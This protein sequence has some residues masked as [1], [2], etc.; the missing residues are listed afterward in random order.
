M[1]QSV[2]FKQRRLHSFKLWTSEAKSTK[3]SLSVTPSY[4]ILVQGQ[5]FTLVQSQS[6]SLVPRRQSLL[7]IFLSHSENKRQALWGWKSLFSPKKLNVS[8]AISSSHKSEHSCQV[9]PMYVAMRLSLTISHLRSSWKQVM[10][11]STY[12]VAVGNSAVASRRNKMNKRGDI[13]LLLTNISLRSVQSFLLRQVIVLVHQIL[14]VT[15]G[16]WGVS[17]QMQ[18]VL[19]TKWANSTVMFMNII[20]TLLL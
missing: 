11:G 2:V 8:Q 12:L 19:L 5:C 13:V 1:V 15:Q 17:W 6:G 14:Q 3:L 16:C 7:A 10:L 4:S 9:I 20:L 18:E